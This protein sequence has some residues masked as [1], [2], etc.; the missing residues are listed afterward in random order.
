MKTTALL[1]LLLLTALPLPAQTGPAA[2]QGTHTLLVFPYSS[3]DSSVQKSWGYALFAVPD[4]LREK[5]QN[6]P[7]F[8]LLSPS[9]PAETAEAR[10]A[11]ARE[12]QADFYL[13]GYLV[14]SGKGLKVFHQLVEVPGGSVR[15]AESQ[16]LPADVSLIDTMT[17]STSQFADWL[18]TGLPP[19]EPQ[20]VVIEKTVEKTVE[21][22][23]EVPRP[24]T[25]NASPVLGG[26]G[27]GG[28]YAKLLDGS[29]LL[30]FNGRWGGPA[31]LE[32][33]FSA[34][35]G[36]LKHPAATA[37]LPTFDILLVP[38]HGLVAV[39]TAGSDL[40]TAGW[41][42]RAGTSAL[43][44]RYGSNTVAAFCPSWGTGPF[45]EFLPASSLSF[46]TTLDYQAAW[47]TLNQTWLPALRLSFGFTF[48]L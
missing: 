8:T 30:E 14:R 7:G 21:K 27:F 38:L 19:P 45:V 36:T 28:V 39:K 33:G 5:L 46:R 26:M 40:L 25:W 1:F 47:V 16:D 3:P 15:H 29:G 42:L 44:G 31:W 24:S 2:G 13:W 23:V 10:L 20:I 12:R 6:Q 48:D 34:G 37:S 4:L 41:E 11:Q 43:F 17:A 22:V 35:L 32:W 9:G 18:K